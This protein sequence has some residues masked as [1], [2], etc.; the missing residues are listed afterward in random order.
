M[1][2]TTKIIAGAAIGAGLIVLAA[3]SASAQEGVLAK[4]LLGAIGIIPRER[5]PIV[6]RER[7]PLVVPQKYELRPP[8]A[9]GAAEA[10]NPNWPD[11]PDVKARRRAAADAAQP[12]DRRERT[13]AID[14]NRAD[15]QEM[16]ASRLLGGGEPRDYSHIPE[17][18]P[19][20]SRLSPAELRAQDPRNNQAPL[21]AGAE[22][23]RRSLTEPPSGY[24]KPSVA[25]V[26]GGF[27]PIQENPDSPAAFLREQAAARR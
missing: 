1:A 16:R 8:V 9:S 22:P 18:N 17:G 6:Y 12:G 3:G 21:V 10:R 24:R 15:I 11:D 25:G 20:K 14:T 19:D 27:E 26:K 7:P 13:R 23:T 2:I 4:N 5:E